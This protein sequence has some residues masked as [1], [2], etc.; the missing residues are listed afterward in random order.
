MEGGWGGRKG[1]AGRKVEICCLASKEEYG[2]KGERGG[3]EVGLRK[4]SKEAG[5]LKRRMQEKKP[6]PPFTKSSPHP[7]LP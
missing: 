2:G 6:F 4:G 1:G 5:G 3:R 7:L